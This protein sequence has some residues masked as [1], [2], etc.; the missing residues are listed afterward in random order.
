MEPN[1]EN[2]NPIEQ[3]FR[4]GYNICDT[5]TKKG[6]ALYGV[7]DVLRYGPGFVPE[8]YMIDISDIDE[9]N[10]VGQPVMLCSADCALDSLSH[11]FRN[12]PEQFTIHC[13]MLAAAYNV[14]IPGL[15]SNRKKKYVINPLNNTLN[16]DPK[17]L[18]RWG[19]TMTYQEYRKHFICPVHI[20]QESHE[21]K[22]VHSPLECDVRECAECQSTDLTIL[23]SSDSEDSG[24]SEVV[25]TVSLV[26]KI[27]ELGEIGQDNKTSEILDKLTSNDNE[28][29]SDD[30]SSSEINIEHGKVIP[31]DED[32]PTDPSHYF[33]D[34]DYVEINDP[35]ADENDFDFIQS[36]MQKHFQSPIKI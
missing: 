12:N 8:N 23:E 20:D 17:K 35:D 33:E 25:D 26:D 19:G 30:E 4:C 18:K 3:C 11:L 22:K 34:T 6:V 21:I 1:S 13:V 15:P 10:F 7:E 2:L 14:Q 31:E 27:P 5:E 32:I 16:N 36:D 9:D 24:D 28:I 29:D